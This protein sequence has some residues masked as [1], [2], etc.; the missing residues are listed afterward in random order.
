MDKLNAKQLI[1]KDENEAFYPLTTAQQVIFKHE[2]GETPRVKELLGTEDSTIYGV[3]KKLVERYMTLDEYYKTIETKIDRLE[4]D[5]EIVLN[6]RIVD[7]LVCESGIRALSARQGFILN[8]L[9]DKKLGYEIL[10]QAKYD[11]LKEKEENKIYFINEG[12]KIRTFYVGTYQF[13]QMPEDDPILKLQYNEITIP[14]STKALT[15]VEIQQANIATIYFENVPEGC[16]ASVVNGKLAITVPANLTVLDRVF[17]ITVCGKAT[18]GKDIIKT[19]FTVKQLHEEHPSAELYIDLNTQLKSIPSIAG[20]GTGIVIENTNCAHFIIDA[21]SGCSAYLEDDMISYAYPTNIEPVEKLY[22]FVINGYNEDYTAS[23]ST[24]FRLKQ[25]RGGSTGAELDIDPVEMTFEAN[26]IHTERPRIVATNCT[27]IEVVAP[28]ECTAHYYPADKSFHLEWPV[29]PTTESRDYVFVVTGKTDKDAEATRTITIHQN[30]NATSI[31]REWEGE[32]MEIT[33]PAGAYEVYLPGKDKSKFVLMK[34][35]TNA[36]V[37]R[38]KKVTSGA[39][40]Y[41]DDF[42][43]EETDKYYLIQGKVPK[44]EPALYFDIIYELND[45]VDYDELTLIINS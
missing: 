1:F 41:T 28:A 16:T 30:G 40:E 36:K 26:D 23:T 44:N 45:L 8:S 20:V 3:I 25:D 27:S 31:V 14:A 37:V 32:Y 15:P 39:A 4:A 13:D 17:V 19:D 22:D 33:Y 2:D 9:I 7:N 34:S 24:F 43:I 12:D 29:N 21:P 18:N 6:P 10:S 11:A 5:Y 38:L 42:Y 35:K